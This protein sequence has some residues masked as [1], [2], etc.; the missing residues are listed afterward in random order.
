LRILLD[1]NMPHGLLAPLRALGHEAESVDTLR[2]KGFENNRLYREVVQAYDLF[3]TKDRA[4]VE[5]VRSLEPPAS[6]KVVLTTLR[7]RPESEFVV[8][9]MDAFVSTDWSTVG[10]PSEWPL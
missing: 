4:F 2:L 1:E 10:N 5:R 6:V 9:F 3:F 7:Q 8:T